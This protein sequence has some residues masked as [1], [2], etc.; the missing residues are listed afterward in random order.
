[1]FK[2]LNLLLLHVIGTLFLG[3]IILILIPRSIKKAFTNTIRIMFKVVKFTTSL[4]ITQVK[5]IYMIQEKKKDE[6]S[7]PS[8][9]IP[10]KNKKIN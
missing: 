1:M 8:N 10:F 3:N 2:E 5:D 7:H 4:V 9:V 6:K